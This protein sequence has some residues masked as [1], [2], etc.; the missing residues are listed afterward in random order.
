MG[1]AL[2]QTLEE[3]LGDKFTPEVKEA[4]TAFYTMVADKMKEGLHE[5]HATQADA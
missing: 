5:A 2:L 3:G 1:Q 4:W